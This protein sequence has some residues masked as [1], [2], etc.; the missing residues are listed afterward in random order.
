MRLAKVHGGDCKIG[1]LVAQSR[2]LACFSIV[3]QV[4]DLMIL[5]VCVLWLQWLFFKELCR[6]IRLSSNQL[7]C[8]IVGNPL[9]IDEANRAGAV[10]FTSPAV[11]DPSENGASLNSHSKFYTYS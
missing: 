10:L 8:M 1:N 9:K 3:E 11:F 6:A 4:S 7:H 5:Q 2:K